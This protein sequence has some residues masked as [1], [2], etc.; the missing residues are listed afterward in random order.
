MRLQSCASQATPIDANVARRLEQQR[1]EAREERDALH[2]DK[3]RLDWLEAHNKGTFGIWPDGSDRSWTITGESTDPYIG[4]IP[5]G[6][7]PTL[8]AAIDAARKENA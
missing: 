3:A 8:R 2:E 1:D 5:M 7:G 6:E 4:E